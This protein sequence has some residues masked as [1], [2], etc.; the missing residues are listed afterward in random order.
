[1]RG[2]L[3]LVPSV[4]DGGNGVGG[5][6]TLGQSQR[7]ER[8]PHSRGASAH[9]SPPQNDHLRHRARAALETA[10]RLRRG[11]ARDDRPDLLLRYA[12]E[13]GGDLHLLLDVIAQALRCDDRF[14]ESRGIAAN[15]NRP[16]RVPFP[17][18][19][20]SIAPE[21]GKGNACRAARPPTGVIQQHATIVSY[22]SGRLSPTWSN[23]PL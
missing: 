19:F 10:G 7:R 16:Q 5:S 4:F 8:G 14:F 12:H 22:H 11:R 15:A 21:R 3:P 23:W 9:G 1:M 17:V 6:V 13:P 18:G 2:V 20:Q